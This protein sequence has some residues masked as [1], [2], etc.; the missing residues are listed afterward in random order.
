MLKRSLKS[1]EKVQL[2]SIDQEKSRR[3]SSTMQYA[4]SQENL[5]SKVYPRI[6]LLARKKR[7]S[8]WKI[9]SRISKRFK[10][11][12]IMKFIK[13]SILVQVLAGSECKMERLDNQEN[14]N[15]LPSHQKYSLIISHKHTLIHT[16]VFCPLH[17]YSHKEKLQSF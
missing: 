15:L 14:K 9:R 4:T 6:C 10:L 16:A 11:V 17:L 13:K 12:L 3:K 7:Q 1:L 5:R 2:L 8:R